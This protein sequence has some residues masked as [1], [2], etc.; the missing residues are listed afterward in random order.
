MKHLSS[1]SRIRA[2]QHGFIA[3]I[4][5]NKL[6]AYVETLTELIDEGNAVDVLYLDFAKAFDK[7]PH[8][9]LL[10]KCRARGKVTSLDRDVAI[11]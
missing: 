1:H 3:E 9:R 11:R 6:L 10:A 8:A 2:S 7:V 4:S 5:I